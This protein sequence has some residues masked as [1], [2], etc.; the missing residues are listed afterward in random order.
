MP[1]PL[2]PPGSWSLEAF[3]YRYHP[4]A[5]RMR[6]IS[7]S[8][9]LGT[10]REV[11]TS[12]C[13]PLPKFSDIRYD[14]DL[15]GGAM[16][17]A[18]CYALHCLRLLGP[19]EPE[20]VSAAAQLRTPTIDR[21]MSAHFRFPGGARG[22]L[23]ASMWSKRVLGI[24]AKVTGDLGELRV[25]NFVAPHIFNLLSV[26]TNGRTHRQRIPGEATYTTQLRRFAAAVLRGEPTLTPASDA[27]VTMG[28]IDQI[29]QAA[30]LPLRGM[31]AA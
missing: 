23:E 21:A 4:L 7:H 29:Y 26:K 24:S 20:V 27:V 25:F 13:F 6:A 2:T 9:E 3:H 16:M 17:D 10:I 31:P 22:H 18:G 14:Y 1:T 12:M 19:G 5:E 28:L 8:G 30:G 11:H 15:G